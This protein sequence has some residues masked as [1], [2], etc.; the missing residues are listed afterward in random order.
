M[1]AFL[2]VAHL[3]AH[4]PHPAPH[5]AVPQIPTLPPYYV[6][7]PGATVARSD[8][9]DACGQ[10]MTLHSHAAESRIVAFYTARANKA[11]LALREDAGDPSRVRLL[12]FQSNDRATGFT[13]TLIPMGG[14]IT[15]TLA[16]HFRS[17]DPACRVG[18]P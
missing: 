7:Y 3:I 1:I 12:T 15:V 10:A 4:P 18:T 16:Y 5:P 2:A 17:R 11:G 9:P 6:V 8:H 13:L 14:A